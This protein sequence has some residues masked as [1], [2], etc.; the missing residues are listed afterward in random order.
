MKLLKFKNHNEDEIYDEDS[1]FLIGFSFYPKDK[2]NGLYVVFNS[3]F[4]YD[5]YYLNVDSFTSGY[6]QCSNRYLFQLM[7]ISPLNKL[8]FFK[9]K[10]KKVFKS[11]WLN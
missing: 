3:P 7:K 9:V 4:K 2:L 10:V 5:S 6:G 8:S 1:L 11:S